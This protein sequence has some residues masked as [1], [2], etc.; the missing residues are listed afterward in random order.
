MISRT[1]CGAAAAI[2]LM[3]AASSASATTVDFDSLTSVSTGSG[4]PA[5]SAVLT[6]DLA[7]LGVVFGRAGVSAG[8]AVISFLSEYVSAPN[9]IAGLEADGSFKTFAASDIYFNFVDPANSS[10][11]GTTSSVA[12]DLGDTGGDVD[13]FLISVYDVKDNL[14]EARNVSS[15]SF[16]N[17]VF[18]LAGMHRFHIDFDDLSTAGYFLDNL[19]FGNVIS[20]IP[21]P[22][23][24]PL[25][26]SGLAGLGFVGRRRR[27]G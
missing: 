14:L 7:N 16:S 3:G 1:L 21:V 12:F 15:S 9:A 5:A 8:V 22:G 19:E 4:T 20:A 13:N 6:D 27:R 18:A 25:M 17:Q 11:A 10:V 2:A 23:A 24:L 26:L